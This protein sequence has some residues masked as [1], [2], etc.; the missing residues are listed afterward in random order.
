MPDPFRGLAQFASSG[1]FF[2]L[3]GLGLLFIAAYGLGVVHTSFSFVLIVLGVA[4]L[5][6]GTGTQGMARF[7]TDENSAKYNVALAGGAG[8]LAFCVAFGIVEY[9]EKMQMAF[10]LQT[11]YVIAVLKPKKDG[12]STF[13]N[14]FPI[15]DIEGNPVPAMKNGDNIF[16]FVPF[17]QAVGDVRQRVTYTLKHTDPAHRPA[18]LTEK[19]KSEFEIRLADAQPSNGGYDFPLF[20]L[21]PPIDMVSSDKS[22]ENAKSAVSEE[23]ATL[24]GLKPAPNT[25]PPIS[26]EPAKLIPQ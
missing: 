4:I 2:I 15:F 17:R 16:V 1:F 5:L 25:E 9:Y 22:N 11:K 21:D 20:R 18:L 12:S 23:S 10:N 13:D 7:E 26:S 14:Y 24:R 6:Y 19:L 8:V 3:L